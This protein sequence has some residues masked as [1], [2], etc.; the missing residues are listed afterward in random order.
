MT[1][2]QKHGYHPTQHEP[3]FPDD[4]FKAATGL[5]CMLSVGA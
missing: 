5:S 2:K 4:K 3:E 1:I